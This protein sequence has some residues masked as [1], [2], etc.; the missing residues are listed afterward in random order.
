MKHLLSPQLCKPSSNSQTPHWAH[1]NTHQFA[2]FV[3]MSLVLMGCHFIPI[4]RW[5]ENLHSGE[6]LGVVGVVYST[7]CVSYDSQNTTTKHPAAALTMAQQTCHNKSV[8][9][10]FLTNACQSHR[11]R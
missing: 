9:V 7:S 6:G 2:L 10:A 3:H 8:L 5:G 11:I 1:V 4:P